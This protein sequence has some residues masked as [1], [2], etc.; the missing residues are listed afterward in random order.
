VTLIDFVADLW[1]GSASTLEVE[2]AK[3]RKVTGA[4]AAEL[5]REWQRSGERMSSWCAERGIN[6]YSLSGYKGWQMTRRGR[7]LEFAEVVVA[8]AAGEA[9]ARYR[10]E[11]GDIVVEVD[12]HF[13]ADTL[14]RLVQAVATC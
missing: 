9:H 10:V 1:A 4:E 7:R 2:M 6:W 12:D 3:G 5:V 13:R 14:R 8:D 11:I